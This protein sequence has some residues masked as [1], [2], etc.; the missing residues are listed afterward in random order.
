MPCEQV[1]MKDGTV[2]LANVKPGEKLTD[3]DKRA[4]DEYVQF[5]RERRAKKRRKPKDP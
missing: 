5:C 2:L 3:E 1:R 4:L